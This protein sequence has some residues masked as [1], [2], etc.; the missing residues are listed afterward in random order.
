MNRVYLI[1]GADDL[2][3]YNLV[4]QLIERG[5]WV[6]A[7]VLDETAISN[8]LPAE[9]EVMKGNILDKRLLEKFFDVPKNMDVVL[10]HTAVLLHGANIQTLKCMT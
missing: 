1:I 3:G 5:E 10:I 4:Q 2:L 7:F 8:Y 6:R 9:V